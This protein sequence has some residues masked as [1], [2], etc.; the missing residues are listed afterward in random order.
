MVGVVVISFLI[1]WF[2]FALMYAGSPLSKIIETFFAQPGLEEGVIWLGKICKD[3]FSK[4]II[5]YFAAYSNACIN[6]IIYA[7]MN[8]VIRKGMITTIRRIT[9]SESDTI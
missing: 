2:P 4:V 5:Y 3:I 9:C 6:P 8:K 1:C 7:V